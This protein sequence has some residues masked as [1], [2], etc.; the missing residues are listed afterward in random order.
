MQVRGLLVLA[1]T[2]LITGCYLAPLTKGNYPTVLTCPQDIHRAPAETDR[3]RIPCLPLECYPL[4]VKFRHL[5]DVDFYSGN[6][7]GGTDAKLAALA[8]MGFTELS[9]ITLLNC[10]LVTDIGI[11]HLA[12]MRSLKWVG[13]EG[14]S[15]T[16]TALETMASNM[17]LT[18]V[19]VANCTQVTRNGL[20][21]LAVSNT[22]RE[23]SFSGDNLSQE[24]VVQLLEA[25]RTVEW[26]SIVDRTGKFNAGMLEML[27]QGKG[28]RLVIR[29]TGALQDVKNE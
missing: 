5:K 9:G 14:A 17:T 3:I 8:N 21:K 26:C 4:L 2:M 10:P 6:G 25:F 1:V 16:D 19:N 29:R 27:A 20:L 11:Q 22:L 12:K 18:A 7:T 13:M 28:L 24:D 15:I 23:I